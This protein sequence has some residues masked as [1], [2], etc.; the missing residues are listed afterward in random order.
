MDSRGF[1]LVEILIVLAVMGT[2]AAIARAVAL[3]VR[4]LAGR[5]IITPLYSVAEFLKE[6]GADHI[7]RELVLNKID[8]L[9]RERLIELYRA[10]L[11]LIAAPD[12]AAAR[13]AGVAE[14]QGF[15]ETGFDIVV[16]L[17]TEGPAAWLQR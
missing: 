5:V 4:V 6:I 1:T 10:G 8:R 16:T 12:E 2:I 17:V 9:P 15:L 7:P 3:A 13:L 11:L 14:L